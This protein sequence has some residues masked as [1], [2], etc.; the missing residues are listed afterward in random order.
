MNYIRAMDLSRIDLNLLK[1]LDALLAEESVSRA[2]TRLGLSQPAVSH[3]LRRLRESFDDALL[4]RVGT[5][6]EPTPRA[7]ALSAPLAAA[8]AAVE[9]VFREEPFEPG[10]SSRRFVLMTPD[11]AVSLIA[12]PLMER[13]DREAPGIRVDV[14]PWRGPS[15]MTPA[16][17]RS[18]DAVVV[19]RGDAFPGFHR[20][21]LYRDSDILAARRGHPA[22]R[23]L[24]S[25]DGFLAARH[26]AVVG[27]GEAADQID[28]WL[29]SLDIERRV[30]LVV[31]SYLQ[32]LH[33]AAASD[34]VAFVPTRLVTATAARLGLE[35]VTPLFDPGTDE[36]FLFY[37]ATA[38]RD[39]ASR[40]F[41]N[42]LL[43]VCRR[44]LGPD[45]ASPA[46]GT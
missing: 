44:D 36:Q 37:P 32:A 35:A 7:L 21:T 6:M 2:A 13:L 23:R 27:Q 10:S 14:V 20:R 38:E 41:R 39:P 15:L 5:R 17:Q 1:V 43:E 11:L 16:F 31:P 19:N 18:L 22:A 4:V 30:A 46:G 42:L 33:V 3:A 24:G 25:R 12:P 45:A 9:A 28:L 29:E 34:L 8:L 40:W 26:V